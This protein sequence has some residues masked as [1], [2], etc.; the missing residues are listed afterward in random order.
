MS[1]LIVKNLPKNVTESKLKELF[2]QKGLVTDLRLKY[3]KDGKFRRFGFVG[4]QTEE[5]A[6]A[7]L[8]YFNNTCIDTCK[9][10]ISLCSTLGDTSR[11]KAWSKYSLDRSK[12][13]GLLEESTKNLQNECSMDNEEV[14]K[15]D[16]INAVL[17]EHKDDPL[18][19]EFLDS[20]ATADILL[21]ATTEPT[22]HISNKKIKVEK[23]MKKDCEE[24]P[25]YRIDQESLEKIEENDTEDKKDVQSKH[26]PLKFFTVKIRGLGYDQKKRHVKQFFRPLVPKSIRVP[27]KI[28]GI[29]YVGFQSE[30][31]MKQAL[32]KDKSFLDGKRIFVSRYEAKTSTASQKPP[33]SNFKWKRQ[34]EALENEESI[35]ESGKMFIRNLAY[36]TNEQDVR[37]LFE[38]YGPLAEVDLPVDKTTRKPKGFGTVTFLMPEHA[39]KAYVELDGSIFHGRMLHILP[40]KGK[41]SEDTLAEECSSFKRKKEL[42]EK[43]TAASSHNWNTLFLGQNAVADAVAFAYGT[44]KEK[45]LEDG[46]GTSVAV[47]LALGETQLVQDTRKFL[48]ENGVHLDAFNQPPEKRST[49]V[50]LVK[51]LPA[52]TDV[53]EIRDIFTR[54]GVLARI[55]VPPSGITA[56]VEFIESSEARQAFKKLAYTRF[57]NL[58]LYLE[59]APENSF[60]SAPSKRT[61]VSDK[62][63]ELTTKSGEEVERRLVDPEKI[64]NEEVK[65]SEVVDDEE[66]EPDTTLFV[67]NLNFSTTEDALREHFTKCGSLHYAMIATKKDPERSG[68]NLSMGYGFVRYGRKADAERA[69]KELQ[70]TMLDGKT[71]E[72]KRSERTLQT[73]VVTTRKTSKITQQTGTKMLIRNVPFQANANE[74]RELFKAFGEIKAVRLPKKMVGIE[75]HKGFAFIEYYEK[76]DAKRAFDTL[77]QSTHLYGR[78]L[79]LEWAQIDES[80]DE[81]RE[82]TAKRFH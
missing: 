35:A 67:K 46:K 33:S 18:F 20:H 79:V 43:A 12:R 42:R 82:R 21:N 9:I 19:M 60:T 41:P 74:L 2:S 44:T 66:P 65:K 36:T 55:V 24:K 73:D 10:T 6:R 76:S 11:P 63:S 22:D 25:S 17:N 23:S 81:I 62:T 69:L 50:I 31:Q 71:I 59:W 52:Q 29:A 54:Y 53:R 34:A 56:L 30:S 26:G 80:V 70:M 38:K 48:E 15:K 39:V 37:T 68:K 49:N 45:V 16:D 28:K 3:T 57:K 72:L 40:G 51:N 77:C 1:R 64:S 47:R 5:E 14:E 13:N 4:F 32:N 7:T 61:K 27:P 58:P 8:E 78:R 75:G